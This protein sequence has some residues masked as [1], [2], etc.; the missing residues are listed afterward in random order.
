MSDITK[1]NDI[2]C[3]IKNKCYRYTSIADEFYQSWFA[4]PVRE[5]DKCE[6][7]IANGDGNSGSAAP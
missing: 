2:N 5:K 3:D 4:E 1:C 6:Y 7:F